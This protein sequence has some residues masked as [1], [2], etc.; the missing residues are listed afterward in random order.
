VA[1]H[2]VTNEDVSLRIFR[3]SLLESLTQVHWLVPP[4]MYLPVVTYLLYLSA[5]TGL[6]VAEQ[7]GAFVAGVLVWSFIEYTIHRFVFHAPEHIEIEVREVLANLKPGEPAFGAIKG[8]HHIFYFFAHGI[9]H[10]YPRD[11]KRL[12][13]PPSVSIPLALVFW[14]GFRWL[15]GPV[16]A[17]GLFAGFM[18]GYVAYDTIHYAVHH[19]SLRNPVMLYLKKLHYRHHYGDPARDYGVSSPLWDFVFRT[20]SPGT[21]G[22]AKDA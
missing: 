8:W 5:G 4:L 13:M 11:S 18:V 14:F 19:F 20:T 10:D 3:N 12:V 15:A 9:H 16:W 1:K 17:P 6:T 22:A 2:Y 7:A 21:S